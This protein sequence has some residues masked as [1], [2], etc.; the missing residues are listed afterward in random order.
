MGFSVAGTDYALD[1]QSVQEIIQPLPLSKLPDAHRSVLGLSDH[2]GDIIPVL[3]LRVRFGINAPPAL[4]SKWIV[5]S[6]SAGRVGF[7]VDSVTEVFAADGDARGAVPALAS[8]ELDRG[9][10]YACRRDGRLVFVLDVARVAAPVFGGEG[11]SAGTR[12]AP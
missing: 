5:A 4:R 9:I 12:E 11:S 10:S 7:V 2:R 6:S 3:D 8:S 1:I